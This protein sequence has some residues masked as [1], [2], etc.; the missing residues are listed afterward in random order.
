MELKAIAVIFHAIHALDQLNWTAL[1]A[2]IMGMV[3]FLMKALMFVELLAPPIILKI[4]SIIQFL[5]LFKLTVYKCTLC[6][7]TCK[8]CDGEDA[9]DCI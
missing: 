9:N 2:I 8:E 5:I 6:D 1:A 3:H 4:Y 7:S